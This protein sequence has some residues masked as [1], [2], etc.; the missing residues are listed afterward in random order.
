METWLG[1]TVHW[2]PVA[3]VAVL[4]AIFVRRR[5]WRRLPFFF[6]YLIFALLAVAV[7]LLGLRIGLK[8]YFYS[9]WIT[10]LASSVVVFL[11]MYEVLLRRSFPSFQKNRFYRN[12][13]PAFAALTVVL[14]VLT[15][16]QAPDKNAAFKMA[17]RAFDFMRTA[18][19]V[20]F[21]ALMAFMGRQWPRYD[22]GITLGFGIQAAVALT[23][24]AVQARMHYRPTALDFVELFAYNL[25]CLIWLITFW[26]P[27]KLAQL[28]P[29]EQLDPQVLHQARG[30][31][32]QLK[33][34]LAPRK[35]KR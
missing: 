3:A 33:G 26:K 19:L 14:A 16:V 23:N 4:A 24:S 25:S 29:A 2:F 17:S 9:Y 31:E 12:V 1:F 35:G 5:L 7:R 28:V 11:P 20:F 22:L 8:A 18:I 10:D 15:A 13:F 30:W 21:I 34:W 32:E 6:L 27:E